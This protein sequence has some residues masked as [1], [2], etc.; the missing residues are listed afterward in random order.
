M[1]V[2]YGTLYYNAVEVAAVVLSSKCSMYV[3]T[4]VCNSSGVS[5]ELYC[6]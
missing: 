3:I 2:L 5:I 6:K 1:L 4:V